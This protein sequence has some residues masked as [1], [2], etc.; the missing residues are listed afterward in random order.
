MRDRIQ[1]ITCL[2]LFLILTG[3]T[4][5]PGEPE[6]GTVQLPKDMTIKIQCEMAGTGNPA[7][8][9][10]GGY[11]LTHWT[12]R[13]TDEQGIPW[14]CEGSVPSGK[15]LLQ[16]TKDR[17]TELLVGEPL[18]STLTATRCGSDFTFNLRL[19]G[20]S[21]GSVV[22][23]KDGQRAPEPKLRIKNADGSYDRSLTFQYG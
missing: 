9:P 17:Q 19:E 7:I 2:T 1:I 18:L 3:P 12:L 15:S 20:R 8:L 22:L 13:R 4:L 5:A 10:Q 21:G 11:T 6:L 14:T 16:V 23:Y